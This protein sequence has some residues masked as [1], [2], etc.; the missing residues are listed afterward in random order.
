MD[1]TL[2][3]I[4]PKA[5]SLFSTREPSEMWFNNVFNEANRFDSSSIYPLNYYWRPY[6]VGRNNADER[7]KH[8]GLHTQ[9]EI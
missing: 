4:K 8:L 2:I 7:G 5:Y 9:E 1:F 6:N 3:K